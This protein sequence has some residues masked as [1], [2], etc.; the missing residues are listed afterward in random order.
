MQFT[1]AEQ[2]HRTTTSVSVYTLSTVK[3]CGF[4]EVVLKVPCKAL[5]LSGFR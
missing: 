4:A 3:I 1:R 2:A 5:L